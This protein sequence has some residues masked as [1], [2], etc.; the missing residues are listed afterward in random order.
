LPPPSGWLT[1]LFPTVYSTGIRTQEAP[2]SNVEKEHELKLKFA[3]EL[4]QYVR[5]YIRLAD[6]KATFL[7]AS[8]TAILAYLHKHGLTNRWI[9]SPMLWNI[10]DMIAFFATVGLGV[11]ALAYVI[12]VMPRLKGSRRSLIY[13][14]GIRELDSADRKAKKLKCR[15]PAAVWARA[16]S[17]Y[18]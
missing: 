4:H 1:N 5:E 11:S 17:A 2:N 16:L 6:Q 18:P 7:F 14:A 15:A 9:K 13:F 8:A 12:T 3:D 10:N